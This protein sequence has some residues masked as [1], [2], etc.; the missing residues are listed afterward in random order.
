MAAARGEYMDI[1]N[2][3]RGRLAEAFDNQQDYLQL[4]DTLGINRS[5]ARSIVATYVDTGRVQ[6]LPRGGARN[7]KMDVDMRNH[8][9]NIIDANPLL[10]L[11]QMKES[12]AHNLPDKPAV[13]TSSVARALD[14]M[15]L[16]LKMAE[17]V[18]DARNAP[19]VV[20]QRL[21]YAEWFLEHGVLGNCVFIDETGYNVWTRR[22]RGRAPRGVPARRVV[23]GQRGRN[24]NVTFAVS[25]A[26]G[27][28]HHRIAFE[29]VTRER[30]EDFLAETVAECNQM[31][32][33]DEPIYLIYDNA[34][35]HVRA[36][37]PDGANPIIQTKRLP[38]YS[39]FLNMT[40]MTHSAFKAAV[41]RTLAQPAWQL[42]VGDRQ[43]AQDAGI[44]LHVQQWR[45]DILR[46]AA[47]QN[48]D[49]ITPGKCTQWYNHSQTY[50][51]RCLASQHIDG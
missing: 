35:P 51:P 19:R 10:T 22:T 11:R 17:D 50:L 36:Q 8:L 27:L 37:L 46:D 6:K 31:F 14:G 24:C 28:V 21:E 16:T 18:P 49:A 9:E 1:S 34:R 20:E 7:V 40:E 25:A 33:A 15:M 5:T 2:T 23:H 29:T 13:S 30:F 38:P 42:R 48:I 12:L 4:A 26:I 41:K 39:P 47:L 43:A 3:D 44:N 45:C 32:P